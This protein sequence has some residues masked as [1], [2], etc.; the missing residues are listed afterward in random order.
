L[1][2]LDVVELAER[3]AQ[4]E[5]KGLLRLPGDQAHQTRTQLQALA[6][7]LHHI[8][9]SDGEEEGSAGAMAMEEEAGERPTEEVSVRE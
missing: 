4:Q 3:L 8:L 9:S 2:C 5:L 6:Q 7:A 1:A